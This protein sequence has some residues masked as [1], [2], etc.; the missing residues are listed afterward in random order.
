MNGDRLLEHPPMAV[1]LCGSRC[2]NLA[3]EPLRP[4]E[5]TPEA[6]QSNG[7]SGS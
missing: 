2:A 4:I 1:T 5:V 6:A 3:D 7:V